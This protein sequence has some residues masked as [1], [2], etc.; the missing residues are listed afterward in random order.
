[1]NS[2]HFHAFSWSGEL[3]PD[4]AERRKPE[5]VTPPMVRRGW[6][7]KPSQML[8]GTY[9]TPRDAIAWVVL[10]LGVAPPAPLD[11]EPSVIEQVATVKVVAGMDFSCDYRATTG[12][13]V[14]LALILC[15]REGI[16]CPAGQSEEGEED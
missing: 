5:S 3:R 4:A 12:K 2:R 13:H 15:P 14:S 9:G 10:R 7:Q 11:V 8:S 6:L 16:T 1:M